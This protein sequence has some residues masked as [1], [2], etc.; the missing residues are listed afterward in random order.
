[1]ADALDESAVGAAAG[2]VPD[3]WLGP[4]PEVARAAYVQYLS[5]RLAEPRGFVQE[6][7]A[8]RGV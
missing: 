5:D 8:A 2:L 4:E 1:M 6:A 7:E 3:D